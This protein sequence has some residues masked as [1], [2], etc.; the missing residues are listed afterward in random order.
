[1]LDIAIIGAGPA[2]LSAAING[3]ARNKD[4]EIFG[5]NPKNT[6]LYKTEN[7]N[8]HLGYENVTGKSMLESFIEHAKSMEIKINYGRI[9]QIL[10][11]GDYFMINFDNNII[12]AKTVILCTGVEK[13]SNIKGESDFV[14]RGLSYCATCDGMLYRGKDVVL[15]AETEEGEE[16]ANFLS[17]ICKSVTYIHSYENL[18]H[19]NGNIKILK[20]KPSEV[21]GEE[22]VSGLVLNDE[23]IKGEGLFFIRENTPTDSLIQNLE[24]DKNTIITNKLMETNLPG[25]FAAG[26]CTGW[27]FQVSKAVGEG[28]I[29]AQQAV[30]FIDKK[31]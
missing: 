15:Y 1:M 2:G 28:L 31:K 13:K 8:N 27:P 26:D 5:N 22:F 24:K 12:E 23:E 21:L 20:G 14:G 19:L 17:E 29:S 4:V 7:I 30:R 16:D 25:V 18:K 9:L 6:W 11:M 3:K 10:P